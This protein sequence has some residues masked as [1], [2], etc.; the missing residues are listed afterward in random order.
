MR[1]R[2]CRGPAVIEIRRHNAGFCS[3]CFV[4]HCREQV[5][6]AIDDHRMVGPDDRVLVAVSGGKDSLALW[7]IL[8]DL[9]YTASGLYLGLGIGGYSEE[10]ATFARAFAERRAAPLVEIDLPDDLGFDIPSGSRAAGRVPCSA[11]GL[12]K[13]HLFNQAALEGGYDAVATGHNLDD[14]AAVLFGNVLRWSSEY[15]ARQL[16][17]LPAGD[18]FVRKVK[19]LVRLGERETAAYCVVRGIDYMVEECPM[20]EG[21]KHLGYKEALNSIEAMSP[22]SKAAFYFGFLDKVSHHF[23]SEALAEEG[24]LGRCSSCGATTTG[25]VCAF[26]RLRARAAATPS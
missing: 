23:R 11:C 25:D 2:R 18:G 10:S 16:P 22:G 5:R 12:S 6:R 1:C 20:A 4:H 15:L 21:N 14:E 9:G 19:P 13:R 3:E 17:V 8:L 7:D 24:Q 26:C